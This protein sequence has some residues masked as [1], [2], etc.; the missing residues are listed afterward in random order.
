M[1]GE[2]QETCR[3]TQIVLQVL[4]SS[5]KIFLSLSGRR[6][7]FVSR[8]AGKVSDLRWIQEQTPRFPPNHAEAVSNISDQLQRPVG[9]WGTQT[10]THKYTN[11]L[12]FPST[13]VKLFLYV[14]IGLTGC[15]SWSMPRRGGTLEQSLPFQTPGHWK[16]PGCWGNYEIKL[17]D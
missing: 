6:G 11:S 14:L 3:R 15:P 16:L 5:F 17:V 9:G 8:W 13:C 10:N 1:P 12:E 7:A 4:Q 2:A